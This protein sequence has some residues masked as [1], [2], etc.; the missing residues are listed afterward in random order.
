MGGPSTHVVVNKQIGSVAVWP[1]KDLNQASVLCLT[2]LLLEGVRSLNPSGYSE[3]I[4][5]L[6]PSLSWWADTEQLISDG[7]QPVSLNLK[8][9][10]LNHLN[11]NEVEEA[12][13]HHG[14]RSLWA[15]LTNRYQKISAS[16]SDNVPDLQ[17]NFSGSKSASLP[18]SSDL[19]EEYVIAE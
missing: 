18:S 4:H 12:V 2:L 1:S 19:A 17:Y 8:D 14:T 13:R 5:E 10:S 11:G 3:A 7:E 15:E 6:S 9:V 16:L